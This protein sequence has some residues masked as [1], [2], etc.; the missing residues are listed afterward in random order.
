[1]C[2]LYKK[3]IA[4]CIL[5]SCAV[6]MHMSAMAATFK[7]GFYIDP[8]DSLTVNEVSQQPFRH[9]KDN[10]HL[11]FI[12]GSVWVK[13]D[14]DT[15]T[16]QTDRAQKINEDQVLILSPF[17]LEKI[18]VYEPFNQG[19]KTQSGGSLASLASRICP[20]GMHCFILTNEENVAPKMVFIKIK[21]TGYL[22][23]K[24]E[25]TSISALATIT[26]VYTESITFA[27]S[28]AL[29][30]FIVSL[31]LILIDRSLFIVIYSVM[32]LSIF[33]YIVFASGKMYLFFPLT[34][35]ENFS[36][37]NY[38][39]VN[40]RIFL[41]I[42]L[43]YAFTKNYAPPNTYKQ[44]IYL[45]LACSIFAFFLIAF[46]HMRLGIYL[47]VI[48]IALN[49]PV[50]FYGL[51]K[52]INM[53]INIQRLLKTSYLVFTSVVIYG[54][55]NIFTGSETLTDR[56]AEFIFFTNYRLNGLA[57][58]VV[59]FL[60]LIFKYYD[61]KIKSILREKD[62]QIDVE[63]S[64]INNEKLKERQTLIDI[65][66]HELKN[67]LTTLRF[68]T[69]SLNQKLASDSETQSRTHRINATLD[70]MDQMINQVANSNKID[71]FQIEQ[72]PIEVN[73]KT[74]ITQIIEDL[75]PSDVPLQRQFDMSVP[76]KMFF[77]GNT[78]MLVLIIENLISNALK[79]SKPNTLISIHG[80]QDHEA[81]LLSVSNQF[82]D[83]AKPDPDKLFERYYR[84]DAFQPMPGMGIG[85]SLIKD[86][87]EKTGSD[88]SF[89]LEDNL[90]TFT[91]KVPL[92]P[93]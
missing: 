83:N 17:V 19:W 90:I 50:Q 51:Q 66:T 87:A 25:I 73:A 68:A 49:L 24:S 1:M 44:M 20:Y 92:C 31:V 47:Y 35:V 81:S 43:G 38:Q 85:L 5:I 76:E 9:Y 82:P 29:S 77:F 57:F 18:T 41:I 70:R 61:E 91:L 69:Y 27:Q 39:F 54:Y 32:Q 40:L 67:P 64:R 8:T 63:T 45:L 23:L 80:H 71:R 89:T 22:T 12:D 65:L 34:S 13:I 30:L 28:I 15:Y 52:S 74:L 6:L 79:Y 3:T 2:L 88:I 33:L 86:A 62:L 55:I 78:Q 26:A 60:V 46:D 53:P 10:L 84:H 36:Y 93:P 14:I 48:T 72:S 16:T 56:G 75:L 4:I 42:F 37:L 59:V 7:Q 11:G 21:H 58:G